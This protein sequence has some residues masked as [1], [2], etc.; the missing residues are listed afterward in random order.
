MNSNDYIRNPKIGNQKGSLLPFRIKFELTFFTIVPFNSCAIEW[1][2]DEK[3]KFQFNSNWNLP[4]G[5]WNMIFKSI[6]AFNSFANSE[7]AFEKA[8]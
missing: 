3:R 6:E 8:E 5:T 4:I 1:D 2:D 7:K